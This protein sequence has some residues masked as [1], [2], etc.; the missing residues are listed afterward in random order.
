MNTESEINKIINTEKTIASS[1]YI[2]LKNNVS[3]KRDFN[4][5]LKNVSCSFMSYS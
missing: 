1:E 3:N 2:G 5:T 4:I